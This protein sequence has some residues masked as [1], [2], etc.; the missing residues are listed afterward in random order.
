M[1]YAAFINMLE[2]PIRPWQPW[3]YRLWA[4]STLS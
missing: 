2:G 3:N 1:R 4:V